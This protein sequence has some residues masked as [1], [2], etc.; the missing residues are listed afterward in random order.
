M[1]ETIR[2]E[3]LTCIWCDN[4]GRHW[5]DSPSQFWRPRALQRSLW[6]SFASQCSVEPDL[7][8][9]LGATF[10]T[11][12]PTWPHW[13]RL[14]HAATWHPNE[15]PAAS[16]PCLDPAPR[17]PP[18][19]LQHLI[20]HFANMDIVLACIIGQKYNETEPAFSYFW[21][22]SA[23]RKERNKTQRYKIFLETCLAQLSF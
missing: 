3:E 18:K 21:E 22:L 8:G 15:T 5:S 10:W 17:A 4:E 13:G 6:R 19:P 1:L 16:V 7:E 12:T 20:F 2:S 11:H 14:P 23:G 9:D